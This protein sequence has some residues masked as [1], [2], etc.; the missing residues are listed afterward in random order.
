M[1][2][3]ALTFGFNYFLN[4]SSGGVH[5]TTDITIQY[6]IHGVYLHGNFTNFAWAKTKYKFSNAA[7]NVVKLLQISWRVS[8]NPCECGWVLHSANSFG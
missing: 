4:F 5:V 3:A 2:K 1:H 6:V 8:V 7:F